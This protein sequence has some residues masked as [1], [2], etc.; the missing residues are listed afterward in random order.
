MKRVV[1]LYGGRSSEHQISC[2]SARSVLEVIDRSRYEVIAVGITRSGRWTVTDGHIASGPDGLPEV[3]DDGNT[4]ALVGTR[5]GLILVELDDDGGR[6]GSR[7][8]IDVVFPLLHGP[9]GEDGTVQGL[10]ATVGVSYVGADVTASSIGIDKSAMKATFAA[11]GLPQ[12]AYQV[13]HHAQWRDEAGGVRARLDTLP[14]PWFVKPARQGS[15]IGISKVGDVASLDTA[16]AT[17]LVHDDIVVVEQG[18]TAARELEMGV[19]G[20]ELLDVSGP[21]E[22]VP[23]SEFYDF[24]AK[25]LASSDLII[26][27]EVDRRTETLLRDYAV[28]AYR[29]IGC[30]GM[31]RIDFFL[32]SD[33]TLLV[34]EIN[35]IPGFT[36]TS[37]F[38]RL[39]Q[40]Q[41]V[42]FAAL[43]DRLLDN[44]M[45]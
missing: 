40:A 7:G 12:S 8:I 2:L 11:A 27:A 5:R 13:V 44:A 16:M 20:N 31:A 28:R 21:G 29:A 1:V 18:V 33:G 6:V 38:P 22:I 34:N 37:M 17:A 26:P 36:S 32:A 25:Y 41:G 42:T 23:A 9:W 35:T 39:W 10:L 45:R 30:R 14:L 3:P 15:S 4:A 43:V 19:V 24:E